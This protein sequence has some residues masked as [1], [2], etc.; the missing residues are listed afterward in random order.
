MV[1]TFSLPAGEDGRGGGCGEREAGVTIGGTVR[2]GDKL[3]RNW[4]RADVV[5]QTE[6]PISPEHT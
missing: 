5:A 3:G 2:S 1:M 6:T 4:A